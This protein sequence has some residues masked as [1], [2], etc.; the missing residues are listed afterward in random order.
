VGRLSHRLLSQEDVAAPLDLVDPKTKIDYYTAVTA[1]AKLYRAGVP[2]SSITAAMVGPT[3]QYW[4]DILQPLPAPL[5]L[6]PARR[7][8]RRVSGGANATTSPLIAAT[9]C[10]PGFPITRLLPSN[11]SIKGSV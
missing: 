7:T 6:I 3:A 8:L 9:T 1:L 2:A 11:S 4:T 5:R 10:F